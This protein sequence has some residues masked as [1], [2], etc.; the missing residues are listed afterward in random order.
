[1]SFKQLE[2]VVERKEDTGPGVDVNG[3]VGREEVVEGSGFEDEVDGKVSVQGCD[4][5]K[6]G[7]EEG[8]DAE[9]GGDLVEG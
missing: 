6:G 1:M 9:D 4:Q 3:E 8:F 5:T 7:N 2:P